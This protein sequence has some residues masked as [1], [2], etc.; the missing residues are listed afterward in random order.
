[1]LK[2][3]VEPFLWP[4]VPAAGGSHGAREVPAELALL[5]EVP[6]GA[7]AAQQQE[8]TARLA[9]LEVRRSQR[10]C[11]SRWLGQQCSRRCW[12]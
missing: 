9:V 5:Q 11:R 1:M 8:A 6:P 4:E 12:R 10:C 2:V 7:G 3:P